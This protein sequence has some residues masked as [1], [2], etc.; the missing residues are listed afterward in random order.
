MMPRKRRK[1]KNRKDMASQ[2]DG[3]GP[4]AGL[5]LGSDRRPKTRG[6]KMQGSAP[7]QLPHSP[8]RTVTAYRSDGATCGVLPQERAKAQPAQ[9]DAEEEVP[10]AATCGALSQER[11]R[12]QPAQD[13]AEKKK[14]KTKR[15]WRPNTMGRAPMQAVS[16]GR[17]VD[18]GREDRK[19][20]GVRRP[21]CHTLHHGLSLHIGVTVR[22]AVYCRRSAPGRNRNMTGRQQHVRRWSVGNN[23]S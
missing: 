3:Q 6:S 23:Q 19:C 13:G 15:I 18:P 4:N 12:A 16:S 20:R 9:D 14:E 1:K 22:H 17:I 2:Y 11:A 8:P 5:I 10:M 21:S 7:A